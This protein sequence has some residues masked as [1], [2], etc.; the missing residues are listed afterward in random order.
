MKL[1]SANGLATLTAPQ[2]PQQYRRTV[3]SI[4]L[5]DSNDIMLQYGS[6]TQGDEGLAYLTVGHSHPDTG[7]PTR[8]EF[9]GPI[10]PY[11]DPTQIWRFV[12][13]RGY[14]TQVDRWH[15]YNPQSGMCIWR[16]LVY[17]GG[18]FCSTRMAPGDNDLACCVVVPSTPDQ[19]DMWVQVEG[20]DNYLYRRGYGADLNHCTGFQ[21]SNGPTFHWFTTYNIHNPPPPTPILPPLPL[22]PLS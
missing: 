10:N 5:N 12:P 22:P 16:D 19:Q 6:L 15:L 11:P 21:T 14:G 8:P 17:N 9:R 3:D 7:E 20:G 2:A 18:D 4:F 13:W 1:N